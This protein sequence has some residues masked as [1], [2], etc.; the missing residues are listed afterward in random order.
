MNTNEFKE[1]GEGWRYARA[2]YY[3]G[4]KVKG[5]ED[6]CESSQYF[7]GCKSE[8]EVRARYREWAR[9]LHTDSGGKKEEF[10]SLMSEYKDIIGEQNS[11]KKDEIHRGKKK[12][13]KDPEDKIDILRKRAEAGDPDAQFELAEIYHEGYSFGS[14]YSAYDLYQ[15]AAEQGF[16]EAQEELSWL[17]LLGDGT[18][19]SLRL[20][21]F[22]KKQAKRTKKFDAK[23]EKIN[24]REKRRM[25]QIQ[26]KH[27]SGV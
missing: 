10:E 23:V 18:K 12:D 19:P 6:K 16:R 14:E 26:K 24:E 27:I 4:V 20:Y 1:G 25:R 3:S 2:H 5:W 22:W 21:S 9:K 17:Y 15:D 13:S 11:A 8:D 7:D